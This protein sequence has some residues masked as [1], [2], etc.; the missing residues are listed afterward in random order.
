MSKRK[1]RPNIGHPRS[2]AASTSWKWLPL[3]IASFLLTGCSWFARPPVVVTE[4][5]TVQPDPP[6]ASLMTECRPLPVPESDPMP[7][8]GLIR[9]MLRWAEQYE[10][11]AD[12]HRRLTEAVK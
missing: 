11:C 3:L 9:V 6:P 7:L 5:V 8:D 1:H 2:S 10:V 12:R 4:Y